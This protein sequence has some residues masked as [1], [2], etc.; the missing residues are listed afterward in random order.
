MGKLRIFASGRSQRTRNQ[1]RGKLFSEMMTRVLNHDGYHVDH[2][3]HSD[4]AQMEIDVQGIHRETGFPFYAVCKYSE[5]PMSERDLQ[6]FFGRYM[7]KWHTDRQCHGLF[8][9][10]PGLSG[11]ATKFYREHIKNNPHVTTFLYDED[12]VLKSISQMPRHAN[13]GQIAAR[14]PQDIGKPGEGILLYTE[15]GI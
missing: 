1:A 8:I 13:P 9:I 12:N 14:I 2:I 15:K 11:R 4:S 5:T 7:I 10:L 6:A 3:L